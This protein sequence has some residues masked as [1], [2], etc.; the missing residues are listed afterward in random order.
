[1]KSRDAINCVC[2]FK[3]LVSRSHVLTLSRVLQSFD[4]PMENTSFGKHL[5]HLFTDFRICLQLRSMMWFY[6]RI[7][8]DRCLTTPMLV[9]E[10]CT[11]TIYIFSWLRSGE[12]GPQKIIQLTTHP[13]TILSQNPEWP[14]FKVMA[15]SRPGCALFLRAASAPRRVWRRRARSSG[16]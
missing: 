16:C 11:N 14:W 3:I 4:F 2:T 12:S 10:S 13:L 7:D 1:M 9:N 8:D 15:P 5:I 6:A